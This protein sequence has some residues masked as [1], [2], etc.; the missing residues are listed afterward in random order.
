MAQVSWQ[1]QSENENN[2][3]PPSRDNRDTSRY[4]GFDGM[5][6]EQRR[7]PFKPRHASHSNNKKS[8]GEEGKSPNE[9]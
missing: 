4:E 8:S 6:Y 2:N 5:N 7:Q 3:R 9:V 1:Q